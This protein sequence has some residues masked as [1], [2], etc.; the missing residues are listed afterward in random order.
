LKIVG[1]EQLMEM[2]E[3][4]TRHFDSYVLIDNENSSSSDEEIEG[5]IEEDIENQR[6]VEQN[7]NKKEGMN[8]EEGE[9]VII[10]EN[11][12]KENQEDDNQNIKYNEKNQDF[13]NI[14]NEV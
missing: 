6:I 12:E 11:L 13:L 1:E 2:H 10:K 8:E 4:A 3:R 9:F 5:G 14:P 7:E